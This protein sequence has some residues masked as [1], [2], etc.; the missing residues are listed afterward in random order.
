LVITVT[1]DDKGDGTGDA[2]FDVNAGAARRFY[3]VEEL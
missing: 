1:A 2:T 3:R